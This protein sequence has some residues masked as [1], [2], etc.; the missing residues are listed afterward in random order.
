MLR[1]NAVDVH[2]CNEIDAS[3]GTIQFWE[4]LRDQLGIDF[5]ET[6]A[7]N[8]FIEMLAR[9]DLYENE[10]T[11]PV[12][13]YRPAEDKY[14]GAYVFD[15]FDGVTTNVVGLDLASLY[16]MTLWMSN[17]SPETLVDPDALELVDPD[18]PV[19]RAPNGAAFRLDKDGVYKRIVDKAIGFKAEYKEKMKAETPGTEAHETA[20][21]QYAA[22][23]TVTNAVYG[24]AGWDRFFLYDEKVAEA[25]TLLGQK[26]IKAT[27][28]Y[29][30][31]HTEGEI[32]YGDTDSNYVS[33]P[34]E[35]SKEKCVNYALDVC[36]R[37]TEERYPELAEEF[38]I[39]AELN[40]WEIE[41]EALMDS[42]FQAGKKKRYAYRA[43]WEDGHNL[44]EPDYTI[45][46]FDAKRSDT[47][48][49]T[50]EIQTDVI[51]AILDGA[52]DQE[53]TD[54]VYESATEII[55]G[56][57]LDRIG[58]PGGIKQDLD[59][60]A[61]ESAHVRG[62]RYM[63]ELAGTEIGAGT[64]P[65]RI[66]LQPT[67]S[68]GE[69]GTYEAV[70][71]LSYEVAD[72]IPDDVRDD[73]VIDPSTMMEKLIVKPVGPILSAVGV[74]V[75]AAIKNQSQAGLGAWM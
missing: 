22:A 20:A 43:V 53:I 39:P 63:N 12:H 6:T 54:M 5:K 72:E 47:A 11:A 41:P 24:V 31:A 2:L 18:I 28:E 37:L 65:K 10:V 74:D 45:K 16:P 55:D 7:N 75:H 4:T 62:A 73:L 56:N 49:L 44:D 71:V 1:Y 68:I 48:P 60:Y 57:D 61:N 67:L 51:Y 30:E 26:C 3:S 34:D 42:Y 50:K 8:Q 70:D 46:G 33:L 58:I 38:G 9:R 52:S 36:D 27:A 23:K 19:C 25:V 21:R 13:E 14:E 35:W 64:K 40:R 29:I 32:I 69:K 17:A 15:P 59:E 66:Y